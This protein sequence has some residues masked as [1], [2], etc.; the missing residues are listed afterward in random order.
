MTTVNISWERGQSHPSLVGSGASTCWRSKFNRTDLRAAEDDGW[1][2][3]WQEMKAV[4]VTKCTQITLFR[5]MVNILL[6]WTADSERRHQNRRLSATSMHMNGIF[7]V[8]WIQM[9]TLWSCSLR[10]CRP[11]LYA[12]WCVRCHH[13]H[14]THGPKGYNDKINFN[15]VPRGFERPKWR[16]RASTSCTRGHLGPLNLTPRPHYKVSVCDEPGGHRLVRLFFCNY[17]RMKWCITGESCTSSRLWARGPLWPAWT[18]GSHGP[19]HS[20][21]SQ[22]TTSKSPRSGQEVGAL[23]QCKRVVWVTW[24][25]WV[26]TTTTCVLFHLHWL[27][28]LFGAGSHGL[29]L[30]ISGC[31]FLIFPLGGSAG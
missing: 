26:N 22:G 11:Q 25:I 24:F 7:H 3:L 31:W 12:R 18:V 15:D 16:L 29:Q 2:D 1:M 8:S 6:V 20:T 27:V 5:L 30:W 10:P 19:Q 14:A 9:S 4:N 21:V 28:I 17:E 23:S 13:G